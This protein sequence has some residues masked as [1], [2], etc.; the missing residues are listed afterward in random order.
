MCVGLGHSHVGNIQ[1]E[2]VR[3]IEYR[4]K[5]LVV[6]RS[7]KS[8]QRNRIVRSFVVCTFQ[9][10]YSTN[11]FK[12]GVLRGR[13]STQDRYQKL[14]EKFGRKTEW[15]IIVDDPFV[16]VKKDWLGVIWL[17]IFSDIQARTNTVINF[18]LPVKGDELM[19][20]S[21]T[22]SISTRTF[23]HKVRKGLLK[24][25]LYSDVHCVLSVIFIRRFV[26]FQ[27]RWG[28]CTCLA[29]TVN[30]RDDALSTGE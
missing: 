12:E 29:E 25:G 8:L 13:H 4:W 2:G 20:W 6:R 14:V 10:N 3:E 1:I 7:K 30:C 19:S 18:R 16:D 11:Q 22:I 17:R 28:L 9:Q 23:F 15:K 5:Y 24:S 26:I 27:S 21:V